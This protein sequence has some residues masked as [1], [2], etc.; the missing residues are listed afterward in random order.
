MASLS[1]QSIHRAATGL[2]LISV[3]SALAFHGLARAQPALL[4]AGTVALSLFQSSTVLGLWFLA[5]RGFALTPRTLI[6][7]ALVLRV[8]TFS[9]AP[10][11]TSD[12]DRYLWDGAVL[13][14]GFDPYEIRPD[15]PQVAELRRLWPTPVEHVSRV[16]IYPPLSLGLFA[17]CAS[18]GPEFALFAWKF[19]VSAASFAALFALLAVLRAR[20]EEQHFVLVAL[21]P[22]W[23]LEGLV[24]AH[25][26]VLVAS[27]LAVV[28]LGLLRAR[29]FASAAAVALGAALKL[30]PGVLGPALMRHTRLGA[31]PAL[32]AGG[33][34]VVLPYLVTLVLG[35]EPFA[36]FAVFAAEWRFGSPLWRLFEPALGDSLAIVAPACGITALLAVSILRRRFDGWTLA[37]PMVALLLVSP[38]V[39]P[40]YL[41]P[42]VVLLP[43]T[44]SAFLLAWVTLAPLTYEVLK[45]YETDGSWEPAA[46]PLA[47]LAVGWLGGSLWDFW[48]RKSEVSAPF[49]ALGGGR[50]R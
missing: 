11:T 30:L 9:V 19:L 16:T 20:N 23:T 46:W 15:D 39:F 47:L 14:E 38:V 27:S 44:R 35:A 2:A 18:F 28:L 41:A 31:L 13:L 1:D 29:A 3:A 37:L 21:A 26:D 32:A 12:V 24:G 5:R 40:W 50:P 25:L 49:P 36:M 42:L 45:G 17:L 6:I 34:L 7:Y 48:H 10:Y 33:A 22:L 4:A 8:V 43:L